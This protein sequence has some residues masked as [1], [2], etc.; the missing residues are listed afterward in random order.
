MAYIMSF[1]ESSGEFDELRKIFIGLDK[2]NDGKL[3]L[4]EIRQG[5]SQVMGKIRHKSNEFEQLMVDLDKD[6]NGVIDYSEFL[7]AA[8]NK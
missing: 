7:T 3:S 8:I 5:L 4:E 1:Y 2:T 6:C